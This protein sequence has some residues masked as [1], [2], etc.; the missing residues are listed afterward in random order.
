MAE[1]EKCD[2]YRGRW[3]RLFRRESVSCVQAKMNVRR[4]ISIISSPEYMSYTSQMPPVSTGSDD[5]D[6]SLCRLF[7]PGTSYIGV[8][9][10]ANRSDRY[11]IFKT[12]NSLKNK[13]H[14]F[15]IIYE[16]ES[17]VGRISGEWGRE[18]RIVSI[19]ERASWFRYGPS[20]RAFRNEHIL[21]KYSPFLIVS[22]GD[23]KKSPD[24]LVRAKRNN[25][26]I[27]EISL[28]R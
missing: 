23:N 1:F 20:A 22:F 12:L 5:V 19:S 26:N 25:I 7:E 11:C 14:T 16:S 27:F 15:R 4:S 18:N 17:I 10:F 13:F 6:A 21:N 24:L 8:C 3:Q 2:R 28:R 9:G